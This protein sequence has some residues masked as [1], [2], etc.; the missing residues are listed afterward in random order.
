LP[1]GA[2]GRGGSLGCGEN[3]PPPGALC[4][5][6]GEPVALQAEREGKELSY[7][8]LMDLASAVTLADELG[9]TACVIVKHNEPC[10]AA[11]AGSPAEAWAAAL[12]SD[13]QSAF[14]G[15]V[16]FSHPLDAPAAQALAKHVIHAVAA[17]ALAPEAG[18]LLESKKNLRVVRMTAADFATSSPWSLRLFGPWGL[19]QRGDAGPAPEWRGVT[20][21]APGDEEMEGLRFAWTV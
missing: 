21:R 8:N 10:G 18:T 13:P 6:G 14:G 17:P 7:N 9:G 2:L 4:R 19:L 16:A 20:R 1:R 3:P 15:I 12:A 11:T 5:G